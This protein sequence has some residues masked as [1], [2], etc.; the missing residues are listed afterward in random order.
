[1]TK[2]VYFENAD[3]VSVEITGHAGYAV[4]GSDIVCSAISMLIQTLIAY[5]ET[6]E[7]ECKY[8]I[9]TGHVFTYAKGHDAK[10]AFSVIMTGFW[11]LQH[12]YPDYVS[13]DRGCA[14]QTKPS[15]DIT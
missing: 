6:D 2:I 13:V 15:I 14:I 12:N 3:E 8:T 7:R 5:L 11:L 10:V 1:M 4:E 9:K